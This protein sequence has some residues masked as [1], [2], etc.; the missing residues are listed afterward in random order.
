MPNVQFQTRVLY[1]TLSIVVIA[2]WTV[3]RETAED[4]K[5][6]IE[7]ELSFKDNHHSSIQSLDKVKPV[8]WVH[9][10][11]TGTSFLNTLIY[12]LCPD[13]PKDWKLN[14][15]IPIPK[16]FKKYPLDEHCPGGFDMDYK[17]PTVHGHIG[18][19]SDDFYKERKGNLVGM[20][21]KPELRM[22]SAWFHHPRPWGDRKATNLTLYANSSKS[23]G[24]AVKSLTRGKNYPCT[25]P[26][27]ASSLETQLAIQRLEGFAFIGITDHW[28]LSICLWHAMFG[29]P[30]FLEEFQN[31]R[32]GGTVDT[33][34]NAALDVIRSLPDVHDEALFTEVE[35]IF[36]HNIQLFGVTNE[37]C[38]EAKANAT[39][40]NT[41]P[42]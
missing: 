3:T 13:W 25:D 14:S 16:N 28:D 21:R 29:G 2:L 39:Y 23:R 5:E 12:G 20:F 19:L 27:A 9:I 6:G 18:I 32:P 38:A 37:T 26:S 35:R 22:L 41:E 31:V 15:K 4:F 30:L 24:C 8:V 40:R 11:K 36:W 33:A 1:S 10:P 34:K 17:S 42:A 7:I